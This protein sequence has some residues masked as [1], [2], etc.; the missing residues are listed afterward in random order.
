MKRLL[1]V[2]CVVFVAVGLAVV[3]LGAPFAEVR[4]RQLRYDTV[5]RGMTRAQVIEIMGTPDSE[6]FPPGLQPWWDLEIP[7]D[8]DPE[9]IASAIRYRTATFYLPVSFE[10]IFDAEGRIVG[11]HRYD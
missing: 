11:K 3:W 2:C 4:D 8:A 6:R 5:S 10:F 7:E 1:A 9:S